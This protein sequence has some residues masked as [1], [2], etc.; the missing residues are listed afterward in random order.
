LISNLSNEE[1]QELAVLQRLHAELETIVEDR[2]IAARAAYEGLSRAMSQPN[3]VIQARWFIENAR[4]G[5]ALAE[6]NVMEVA[7]MARIASLLERGDPA[8]LAKWREAIRGANVLLGELSTRVLQ[9]HRRAGDALERVSLPLLQ[10]EAALDAASAAV[11]KA[12]VPK[13][14]QELLETLD[15]GPSA[16]GSSKLN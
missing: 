7:A 11:E 4:V 1:A 3:D 15:L 8:S 6:V 10:A 2:R 14:F 5:L 9:L 16:P 13:V 12:R